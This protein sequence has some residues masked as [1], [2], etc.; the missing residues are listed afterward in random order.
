M[1][2]IY[3]AAYS[4]G[5]HPLYENDFGVFIDWMTETWDKTRPPKIAYLTWDSP[6]GRAC[7]TEECLAYAAQKGVGVGVGVGVGASSGTHAE[8]SGNAT[9]ANKATP[10]TPSFK[11]FFVIVYLHLFILFNRFYPL[12]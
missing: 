2:A 12:P 10:I 1:K 9:S 11:I 7:C 8:T 3:P 6:L 4:F 5:T